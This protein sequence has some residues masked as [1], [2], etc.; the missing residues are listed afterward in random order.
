MTRC[1]QGQYWV[2]TGAPPPR[3]SDVPHV[4][5]L[6]DGAEQAAGPEAPAT[7]PVQ[8][9]DDPLVP[10]AFRNTIPPPPRGWSEDDWRRSF[11]GDERR[12]PRGQGLN[13]G[14]GWLLAVL[15]AI[16][17]LVLVVLIIVAR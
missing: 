17:A 5:E 10:E 11:L 2:M 15:F 8:R 4:P 9:N 12:R 1:R 14:K 6:P 16:V 7:R 3:D 13:F